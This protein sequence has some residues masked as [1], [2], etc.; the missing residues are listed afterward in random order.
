MEIMHLYRDIEAILNE[1][2]SW[3]YYTYVSGDWSKEN[4][5]KWLDNA[6]L[7]G[8]I[9]YNVAGFQ[10]KIPPILSCVSI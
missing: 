2:K 10:V 4:M 6:S 9:P 8:I 7:F 5:R 3:T 1:I